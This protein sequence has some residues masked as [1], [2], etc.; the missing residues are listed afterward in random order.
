MKWDTRSFGKTP[1]CH[2]SERGELSGGK[3]KKNRVPVEESRLKVDKIYINLAS[4]FAS[5][6]FASGSARFAA[7]HFLAANFLHFAN[8][9]AA[10]GS[11]SGFA[12]GFT[13]GSGFFTSRSFTSG[14]ASLF[15]SKALEAAELFHTAFGGANGLTSGSFV[16]GCLTSGGFASRCT[17]S[18]AMEN[19]SVSHRGAHQQHL[20]LI[21]I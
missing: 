4:G 2:P 5:R 13:S 18:S 10:L 8:F 19:A 1:R 20:S 6:G 14:F 16:T 7:T 17:A 12:G 11:A 21:H 9:F 15:A 3:K